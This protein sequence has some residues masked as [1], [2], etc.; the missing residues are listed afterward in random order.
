MDRIPVERPLHLTPAPFRVVPPPPRPRRRG[1]HLLL[2]AAT[3]ATL[4]LSGGL[5][6]QP[7]EPPLWSWVEL[8][9]PTRLLQTALAGLPYALSVLAILGAHEMGHYLA[10]RRYG[11]PATPPFFLPGLPPLG[12]FGAVIRIRGRIP[13]RRALFD[14]AAAGPIAGFLV[15]VPVLVLG[16]LRAEPFV[17][18]DGLDPGGAVEL[19]EPV[20]LALLQQWIGEP[21][22]FGVNAWIGAGW[23]GMLVTSLNLFPVGQLDGGHAAYAC[24]RRLH[25]V[26]AWSTIV[27]LIGVVAA[28]LLVFRQ[29]PFYLVWLGILGW[30]RDR[31]PRLADE[32]TPLG[33]GRQLVAVALVI[34]FG[35]SFIFVPVY[36]D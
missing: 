17:P 4:S 33:A 12:T 16:V 1:L 31:H 5:V 18:L 11:I 36:F 10:C 7:V 22:E 25:R 19:G 3:L 34:V 28:Q 23:V 27:A 21:G 2:G 15:A 32:T 13:H 20:L 35:L 9:D 26:L 8:L 30:M 14:V 24:S 29:F 6:W